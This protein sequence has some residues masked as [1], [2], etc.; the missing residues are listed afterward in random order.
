[1]FF[2]CF[3]GLRTVNKGK[4]VLVFEEMGRYR[5][6]FG[7]I[8]S[9]MNNELKKGVERG[10]AFVQSSQF[11]EVRVASFWGAVA[12]ILL[13]QIFGFIIFQ[14]FLYYVQVP[15]LFIFGGIWI[16]AFMSADAVAFRKIRDFFQN[17]FTGTPLNSLKQVDDFVKCGVSVFFV[18]V[19]VLFAFG[20]YPFPHYEFTY[21]VLIGFYVFSWGGS[22]VISQLLKRSKPSIKI[23]RDRRGLVMGVVIGIV[24]FSVAYFLAKELFYVFGMIGLGM[25]ILVISSWLLEDQITT[26]VR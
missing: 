7:L 4:C 11:R 25:C 26:Q 9:A 19:L 10:D 17:E 14:A 3:C 1:M 20:Y 18:G 16:F 15:F 12:T 21:G 22:L 8:N 24:F 6:L 13:F 2:S 5:Y 23:S